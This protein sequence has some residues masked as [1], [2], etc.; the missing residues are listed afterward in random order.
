MK[1]A[2]DGA[3]KL[4]KGSAMVYIESAIV[5][6]KCNCKIKKYRQKKFMKYIHNLDYNHILVK[7]QKYMF[8]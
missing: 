2:S 3:G 7:S 5:I 4:Q 1:A 8:N 6:V